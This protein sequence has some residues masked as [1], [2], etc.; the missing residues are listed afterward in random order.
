ML[1][2]AFGAVE[3][4]STSTVRLLTFRRI[5]RRRSTIEATMKNAAST[6]SIFLFVTRDR[7]SGRTLTVQHVT[8]NSIVI[9]WR[10]FGLEDL[11]SDNIAQCKGD[12]HEEQY[13][14]LLFLIGF[15]SSSQRELHVT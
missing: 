8:S 1:L 7:S 14:S 12:E 2:A 9:L 11:W 13:R 3:G 6:V 5:R 4:L 15:V 10:I